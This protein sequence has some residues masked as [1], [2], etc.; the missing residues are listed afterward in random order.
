MEVWPVSKSQGL[1]DT[2]LSI[3]LCPGC[4]SLTCVTHGAEYILGDVEDGVSGLV[5]APDG[6]PTQGMLL[7]V[8]Q[9]VIQGLGDSRGCHPHLLQELVITGGCL[10][11]LHAALSRFGHQLASLDQL[12]LAN[13]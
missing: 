5:V 2:L 12:L 6:L 10:G 11:G 3:V 13:W 7:D 4:L 8:L 9:Q 1:S